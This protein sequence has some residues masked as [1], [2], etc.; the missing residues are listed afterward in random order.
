M[1]GT[2]IILINKL[3]SNKNSCWYYKNDML[4][5]VIRISLDWKDFFFI[6]LAQ[7]QQ[8]LNLIDTRLAEIEKKN[9]ETENRHNLTFVHLQKQIS[10][11]TELGKYESL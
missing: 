7:I 6:I 3:Q 9:E 2:T 1:I 10:E 5:A 8:K 4:F 11:S